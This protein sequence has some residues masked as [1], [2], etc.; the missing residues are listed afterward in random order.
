MTEEEFLKLVNDFVRGHLCHSENWRYHC[1]NMVTEKCKDNG[2]MEIQI[3]Y[4][5]YRIETGGKN[6]VQ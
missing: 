4:S 3:Q 1:F 6:D 5:P 2:R